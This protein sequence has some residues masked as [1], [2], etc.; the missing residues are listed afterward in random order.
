MPGG[1]T[2]ILIVE[3]DQ[4]TATY[5]EELLTGAGF[6]VAGIAGSA[7]EALALAAEHAPQLALI[8]IQLAGAAGGIPLADLL[9]TKFDMATIFLSDETDLETMRRAK[10]LRPIGFLYK[11]FAP[12]QIFNAIEI[13]LDASS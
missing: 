9:A 1:R 8:D 4:F 12:S 11:P 7:N 10:A 2:R 3:P 6:E 13:A 5:I